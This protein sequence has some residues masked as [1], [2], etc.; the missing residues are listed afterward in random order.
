MLHIVSIG[1]YVN[2]SKHLNLKMFRYMF[3]GFSL[4]FTA[5]MSC[6]QWVGQ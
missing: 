2:K 6:G 3:L 4:G 5:L 1:L